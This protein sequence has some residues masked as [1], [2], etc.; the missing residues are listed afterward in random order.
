MYE[1]GKVVRRRY[2]NFIK[3]DYDPGEI[4]I[5]SSAANRCVQSGTLFA[6]GF[7]EEHNQ[8][9]NWSGNAKINYD[10]IPVQTIPPQID[11]V[12]TKHTQHKM[13]H[14]VYN[15]CFFLKQSV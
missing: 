9:A 7:Y 11:K 4:E 13:D 3:T 8:K 2:G 5:L 15:V 1:L 14:C 12:N 6:Y 10:P